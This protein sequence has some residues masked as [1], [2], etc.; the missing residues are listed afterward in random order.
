MAKK[1]RAALNKYKDAKSV[2]VD[3]TATAILFMKKGKSADKAAI[4]ELLSGMRRVKVR[5][6]EKKE[7]A[8][9]VDKYL[10]EVKGYA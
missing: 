9:T 5:T 1:V 2:V 4:N 8:K 3:S 7:R 6:L 10:V